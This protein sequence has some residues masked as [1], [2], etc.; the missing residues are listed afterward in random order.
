MGRSFYYHEVGDGWVVIS[1]VEGDGRRTH[2][3]IARTKDEETAKDICD[4]LNRLYEIRQ[5]IA[6]KSL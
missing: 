4:G 1:L 2:V 5:I 6:R 3:A